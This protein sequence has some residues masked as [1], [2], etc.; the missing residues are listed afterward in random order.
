[1]SIALAEAKLNQS[2]AASRLDD[3]KGALSFD[4]EAQQIFERAGDK[5]GVARARYRMADLLFRQGQFAQSNAVLELCLRDFRILGSDG[6]VAAT[7]NDIAGGLMEM[8]ETDRAR[9]MYEQSLVARRL[10]RDKR[11]IA[12]TM[13]NLG[14]ILP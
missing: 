12:D 3:P 2:Q 8:G 9:N 4:E 1:M 6:Y 10:V 7:L 11:G 5:Y 13:T 14:I